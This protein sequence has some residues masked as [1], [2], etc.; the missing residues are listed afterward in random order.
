MV[1]IREVVA[2]ITARLHGE[3]VCPCEA[4]ARERRYPTVPG[5]PLAVLSRPAGHE[6][7]TT[8]IDLYGH[9]SEDAALHAVPAAAARLGL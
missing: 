5:V 2:A 4:V 8:T 3:D 9:V 7:I 1:A 6:S